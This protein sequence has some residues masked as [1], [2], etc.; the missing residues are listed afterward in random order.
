[1]ILSLSYVTCLLNSVS[2]DGEVVVV[3]DDDGDDDV[4]VNNHV[5]DHVGD[6]ID[7]ACDDGN[8]DDDDVNSCYD[9]A[10]TSSLYDICRCAS[11]LEATA[12]LQR[13]SGSCIL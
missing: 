9:Y 5:D 10:I 8:D 2:D 7:D 13:H 11:F 6:H 4:V 3:V 1:M 12:E